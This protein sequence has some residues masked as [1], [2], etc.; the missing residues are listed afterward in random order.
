[1]IGPLNT[2]SPSCKRPCPDWIGLL[3]SPPRLSESER[4]GGCWRSEQP[5][6][7]SMP[8]ATQCC[9]GARE[10]RE[11]YGQT[12][13]VPFHCAAVLCSW[14][15]GSFDFPTV[16]RSWALSFSPPSI[17]LSPCPF[18]ISLS[19]LA[20]SSRSPP[21]PPPPPSPLP[22]ERIGGV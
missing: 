17:F 16:W 21:F 10:G 22:S 5:V 20:Q 12:S 6:V 7:L 11:G 8:S 18:S 9:E 13:A 14:P 4:G 2:R 1:M 3:S 19:H 15:Y